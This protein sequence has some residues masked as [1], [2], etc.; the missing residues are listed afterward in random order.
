MNRYRKL[1][2]ISAIVG[3]LIIGPNVPS[4]AGVETFSS[5]FL[6]TITA[7]HLSGAMGCHSGSLSKP[8]LPPTACELN[9]T[10]TGKPVYL[11]GD[12]NADALSEAVVNGASKVNRPTFLATASSCLFFPGAIF[13]GPKKTEPF[14]PWVIP[15]LFDHCTRYLNSTTKWLETAKPGLVVLALLD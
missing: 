3:L 1:V 12:S 14:F 7:G 2:L 4:T 13:E 11:I 6:Q 5:T 15:N 8:I 10:M 9:A